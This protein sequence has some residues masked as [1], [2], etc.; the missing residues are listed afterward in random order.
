MN[1]PQLRRFDLPKLMFGVIF[2]MIMIIASFWVVQPFIM[3][4]AWA[5]MVVIATWPLLIRLQKI[6][7]GK[8][9]LAAI[10][11]TILLV[12]LFVIP[13]ALLV[14]SLVENSG[15][16]I[17]WASSPSNLKMPDV[18]WLKS[19]PMVGNKLYS[20]WHSV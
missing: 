4:F 7:W 11:M 8:R 16:L 15:P 19:I 14:S 2:I 10:I 12:L 13:I 3:G 17:Q 9:W 5:G 1:Y 20:G 18:T 6:L